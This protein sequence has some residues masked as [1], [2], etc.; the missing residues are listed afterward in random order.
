M[1]ALKHAEGGPIMVEKVAVRL[2]V[3]RNAANKHVNIAGATNELV[4]DSN[5]AGLGVWLPKRA[6]SETVEGT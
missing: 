3:S 1:E 2:Q 6:L 5:G 4:T